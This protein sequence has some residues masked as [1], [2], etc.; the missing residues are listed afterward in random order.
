[1]LYSIKWIGWTPI[2]LIQTYS[3]S[4]LIRCNS[5]INV[6]LSTILPCRKYCDSLLFL[7]HLIK[8]RVGLLMLIRISFI[9]FLLFIDM[10]PHCQKRLGIQGKR[11]PWH[12]RGIT[13]AGSADAVQPDAILGLS[14]LMLPHSTGFS[15]Q[16]PYITL[17]FYSNI[18]SFTM[19]NESV[20]LTSIKQK[21]F[22]EFAT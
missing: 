7:H 22:I 5:I 12:L 17:Q 19:K 16:N 18:S 6:I 2:R 11:G 13:S 14:K 9:C 8:I 3:I 1:M 10:M 20:N 15:Y 21:M 4:G